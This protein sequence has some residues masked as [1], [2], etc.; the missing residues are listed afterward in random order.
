MT[1][2]E[3]PVAAGLVTSL[4]RPGG[5]ATGLT[6]I[7]RELSAK[8]LE[9]IKEVL[10][11]LSRVSVLWNPDFPGKNIELRAAQ[12][13]GQVLGIEV[14]SLEMRGSTDIDKALETALTAHSEAIITLPDPV[15]NANRTRII[16]WARRNRL[17]TMFSQRPHVDAGGLK[18]YGP[19]YLDMFRGAAVYVDKILKGSKPGDLPVEQPAKFELVINLKTA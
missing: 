15:T 11:R 10:P 7:A 8:R 3:D 17:A 4:A 18:S 13:A 6:T 12:D 5:K 1:N 19:I 2:A 16:E 9:I 14:H